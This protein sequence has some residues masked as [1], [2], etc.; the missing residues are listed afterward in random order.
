MDA[1]FLDI[2]GTL[3]DSTHIV[4]DAWNEVL[5]KKPEIDL[6]ITPDLLKTLFGFAGRCQ[7]GSHCQGSRCK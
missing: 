6:V 4:A 7:F 1:I 5:D 2:D 3:W